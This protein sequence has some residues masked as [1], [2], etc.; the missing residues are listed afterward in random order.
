MVCWYYSS[1]KHWLA[2]SK[3]VTLAVYEYGTILIILFAT[4]H[5]ERQNKTEPFK[6]AKI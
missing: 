3:L 1:N 5:T 6:I 4:E 2:N